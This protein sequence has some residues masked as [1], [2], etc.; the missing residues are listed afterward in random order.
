MPNE[1]F[2]R[3][4]GA[5]AACTV[6]L[7]L[8]HQASQGNRSCGVKGDSWFGSVKTCLNLYSRGMEGIFQVKTGHRMYPKAFIEDSLKGMPGGVHIV[9]EGVNGPTGER[10]IAIGYR[11]SS[12]TTCCFVMTTGAGTTRPGLPYEMKYPTEQGNVGVRYVDRPD[13]ISRY[14]ADSNCVDRHNQA[15]QFELHLEK[16][17]VT[18][19]PYFRLHTTLLGICVTDAWKLAHH[20]NLFKQRG[21][22]RFYQPCE[23]DCSIRKFAG[24]L[25]RQLLNFADAL[26]IAPSGGSINPPLVIGTQDATRSTSPLTGCSSSRGG[27]GSENSARVVS[28]SS[29]STESGYTDQNGILHIPVEFQKKSLTATR[30]M[31]KRCFHCREEGV[32]NSGGW[33][34]HSCNVCQKSYCVPSAKKNFRDCFQAH[35]LEIRC[36]SSLRSTVPI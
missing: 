8:H 23:D 32:P 14:F 22:V 7:G 34:R 20:H 4:I 19:D 11:Y 36:S 27:S 13:V 3:E 18:M 12:K 5:T 24:I 21:G 17:W 6:R 15:R 31:P 2:S 35:V 28:E 29:R 25:S 33:A 26:K 16:C 30:V 10:L 1:P 9:L